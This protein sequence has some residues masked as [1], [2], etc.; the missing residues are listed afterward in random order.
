MK[1]KYLDNS[2]KTVLVVN[3]EFPVPTILN[4]A[5]HTMLGLVA[6]NV[7]SAWNLLPYPSPAF[8][9]N[10]HIS[11]YPVIVLRAKRSSQ[12]ERLVLQLKA[13][14]ILHNV[15]I[16]SMVGASATEQQSATL[17]ARPGESRV[18]CIGLFGEEEA[19][20]PAIKSFSLYKTS[21]ALS[22]SPQSAHE[23]LAT[24]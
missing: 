16:D 22:H 2:R 21:D 11:E 20:R 15:F 7:P 14:D 1:I 8:G 18:V 5:A 13:A 12:L 6:A 9:A 4:A 17:S 24:S 19:I 23:G 3:A 10:C